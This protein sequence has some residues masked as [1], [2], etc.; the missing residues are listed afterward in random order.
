MHFC[1]KSLSS[2]LCCLFCISLQAQYYMPQNK[3]W[4]IS[5]SV[6]LN[7]NN[8]GPVVIS[9][10]MQHPIAYEEGCASV[11]NAEGVLLFYS[12][13]TNVWDAAHTVMPHGSIINGASN[14]TVST[15]QAALIVPDP[16]N[17][18]RYFLFSLVTGGGCKL[19][20]N[21]VDMTLNNGLGD[22]D[23]TYPLRHVLLS[24]FLS[25]KMVAVSGCRNNVWVLVINNAHHF[26]AFE[27][28]TAGLN[29][30]PVTSIMGNNS[31]FGSI[32]VLKI[33]QARNRLVAAGTNLL[34]YNFDD[35]TGIVSNMQ[36]LETNIAAYGA[37]FSPDDTKLYAQ[38]VSTPFHLYQYN[39]GA[40]NPQASKISLGT[41]SQYT[42]DM[43]LGPDG[44]IYF[45]ARYGLYS[46]TCSK[47]ISRINY[48][49]N[50]GLACGYQDSIPGLNFLGFPDP[51]VGMRRGLPNIVMVP[52]SMFEQTSTARDTVLCHFPST[53]LLQAPV[54]ATNFQWDNGS[55]QPQRTVTQRGTYWV[56]YN[57]GCQI[58]TDTFH[59]RGEDL[60]PLS[61]V[62][63]NNMLSTTNSFSQYQWY[64]NGV[65]LNGAINP[66]LVTN[67]NGLYSVKVSNSW[68]CSDS[69]A[70][71]VSITGINTF[72][73][74][75]QVKVYPNPA[76][77]IIHISAPVSARLSLT[78]LAGKVLAETNKTE[79]DV[80]AFATGLYLL[81]ISNKEGRLLKVVKVVKERE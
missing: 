19:F 55:N 54:T 21:V 62:L 67:G 10:A 12:N 60:P 46:A 5:K 65:L 17:N 9:T 41:N 48:P 32:G 7:F 59:L 81:R 64:K 30:S 71:E 74:P 27:I 56:R 61:L 63:N 53:Y 37:T 80:S 72:E 34:L 1:F 50:A 22:I 29:T 23:T 77:K 26:K 39:L 45:G 16:G 51:T 38:Q 31:G 73:I 11:A 25:E 18:N 52:I 20:C 40:A 57:T 42:G 49:N 44:K 35:N 47:Y 4:A 33:N 36:T 28:T 79:L 43:Q 69:A 76:Q 13:G 2:L 58:L 24:D 75:D 66:T 8:G 6:G 68:G 3:V 14:N 70:Y 15:T 78:N